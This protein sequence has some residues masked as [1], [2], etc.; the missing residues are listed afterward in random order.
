MLLRKKEPLRRAQAKPQWGKWEV[1][2]RRCSDEAGEPSQRD[3]VERRARR[4][5]EP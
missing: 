2:A 3:P 1:G 4:D 5:K